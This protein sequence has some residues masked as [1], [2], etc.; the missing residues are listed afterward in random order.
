MLIRDAEIDGERRDLRIDGEHIAEIGEALRAR[1]DERLIDA[2]G[3]LLIP[4]LQDHHLHLQS[5]AAARA[6]VFCGP[7]QVRDAEALARRLREAAAQG[8]G[9]LRGIGFHESLMGDEVLDRGWLDRVVPDRPLRVQQRSGRLW[10][11]NSCALDRLGVVDAGGD[12]PFERLGG[13]LS[14]RLYDADAWLRSRL[15]GQRPELAET[16]RWL[17]SRGVTGLTDTSHDNGPDELS[18]FAAAQSRGEL[19][20]QLVAMG[21]AR[22]DAI[23]DIDGV[24]RGA[25]KFH[26]HDAGLP[27]LDTVIA[28]IRRSRQAGRGSAFHCVSRTDL[29]FALAALREAGAAPGDRIEHAGVAPPELVEQIAELGLTVV[30]QPNFIAERGDAYL[31]DVDADD[32]PWLYRLRGLLD[33]GIPLAGSTDAPFGDADPWA[34][35]QAAV[36]RRAPDGRVVGAS[37][38]LTPEQA[39]RLFLS[40]LDAPGGAARRIVT[41][42]KADLCLLRQGW[43]ALRQDLAAASPR[44]TLRQGRLIHLAAD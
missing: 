22:L 10:I 24:R 29:V 38:A 18:H 11:F 13:R 32:R 43:A 15:R 26:L 21:D 27:D 23:G 25:H 31:D 41:G 34:A 12:D 6:S 3:G 42:A 35:M 30:T 16:S 17:A 4:G 14:G 28:A 44:A 1:P 19:L 5:L 2:E 36:T 37:E 8:S 39:L 20:Q 33:A 9:W 40:P 7:P